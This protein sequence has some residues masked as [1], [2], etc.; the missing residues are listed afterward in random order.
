[1]WNTGHRSLLGDSS[2]YIGIPLLALTVVAVAWLRRRTIV[3]VAAVTL[4]CAVAFSLGGF[5]H[6]TDG[7]STTVWL[8]WRSVDGIPFF[9]N[10]LPI[11]VMLFGYL[12]LALL[13][14][15][16]LDRALQ[17]PRAAG[18]W[19]TNLVALGTEI[20]RV[21]DDGRPVPA[22]LTASDRSAYVAELQALDVG[23]VVV[24]PE[25]Y[26]SQVAVLFAELLG[27]PGQRAGGVV[28]WYRVDPGTLP[29]A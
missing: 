27:S 20:R 23:S 1:M 2:V 11:R 22:S 28:V 6:V 21:G 8:P 10:I 17:N 14:A 26:Q 19:G 16:F 15:L 18:Q 25:R 13:I 24:G 4:T 29:G 12:A 7:H 3:V 9:N 5:L